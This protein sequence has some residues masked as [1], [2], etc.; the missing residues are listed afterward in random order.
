MYLPL[1]QLDTDEGHWPDRDGM[2]SASVKSDCKALFT[3]AVQLSYKDHIEAAAPSG[4]GKE[5]V[6]HAITER[7]KKQKVAGRPGDWIDGYLKEYES[8]KSLR[9]QELSSEEA[10]AIRGRVLVPRLRM[11]LE[12]KRDGRRKRR[13]ILQGLQEPY[14]WDGGVSSDSP[15]AYM[16]TM[17]LLL[18]RAGK[19]DE[20][21]ARDV[22]TAFLQST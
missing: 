19:D 4:I 20:I 11:I 3:R 17:R 9:L 1:Q 5:E 6:V 18:A 12:A 7:I 2:Q 16:S 8:D 10:D 14:S 21:T 13:L 22:S 15:V